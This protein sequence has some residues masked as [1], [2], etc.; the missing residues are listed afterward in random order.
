MAT[1]GVKWLVAGIIFAFLWA[2]AATATKF[3]LQVSQPLVMALCRFMIAGILMLLYCHVISRHR[4]PKAKEWKQITIYGLLNITIYLG[5]YV[6][7]MQHVTAGVGALSIAS[8]PV[9]ISFASLIFLKQPL[10]PVVLIALILGILG[11][12][13]A[14][15]PLLKDSTVT[16][17]GLM[18][19]L[20]SMLSYSI[21]QIY[22][23]GQ[24]WN[25]LDIITINGWQTFIGGLFLLPLTIILY[26]PEVNEFNFT[27]WFSTIWLAVPVSIFA[28]L[29]WLWLLQRDTVRAG[30]WLF[31]CPVFGFVLAAFFLN[32]PISIYTFG[33]VAL[34]LFGLFLAQREKKSR[35]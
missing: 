35:S 30:L 12:I 5:C 20:F 10:K 14:S 24:K 29:I 18:L 32:D 27:F 21:G 2:S 7:A 13:L 9:F 33:G 11:L 23:A 1:S 26:K 25:Q 17:G 4:L 28:M 3:G 16:I 19:L 8:N 34:V 22:F 15:W 31:L 6:F